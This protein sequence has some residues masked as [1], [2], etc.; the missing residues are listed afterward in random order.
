MSNYRKRTKY[1]QTYY[2]SDLLPDIRILESDG[3]YDIQRNVDGLWNSTDIQPDRVSCVDSAISWARSYIVS[4][5]DPD[6]IIK[7]FEDAAN[8]FEFTQRPDN[9][10]RKVIAENPIVYIESKVENGEIY[11]DVYKDNLKLPSYSIPKHTDN[12]DRWIRSVERTLAKYEQPIMS[13]VLFTAQSDRSHVIL[14][15][16]TSRDLSKNLVRVK[17]S[18]VWAYAMNPDKADNRHGDML[19]QFKNKNG[20]P[21]DIYIYY[22]VPTEVYRRWVTA[23][24]KGHYFWQFIRNIYKYS[25]LTGNKRGVLPN[26]IN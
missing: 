10:Y 6:A 18:N 8:M 16:I 14:C 21:G 1:G 11:T 7:D 20:G 13:S 23:P 5:E 9:T 22:D 4:A 26:A 24:S 19:A 17:S 2:T 3:R 15:A 12:I 25:K